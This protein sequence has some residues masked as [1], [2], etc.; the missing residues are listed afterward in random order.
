M[1]DED[2]AA[3]Y[4]YW[5]DLKNQDVLSRRLQRKIHRYCNALGIELSFFKVDRTHYIDNDRFEQLICY[6]LGLFGGLYTYKLGRCV[7]KRNFEEIPIDIIKSLS[8]KYYET[9]FDVTM[10][11]R[12][13][14]HLT[15]S[16]ADYQEMKRLFVKHLDTTNCAY[17]T[18]LVETF[19][20]A[21]GFA[22]SCIPLHALLDPKARF[23]FLQC[24]E[25]DIATTWNK[26]IQEYTQLK[27][28][29]FTT[30]TQVPERY[31]YTVE[32]NIQDSI[33][34]VFTKV[35]ENIDPNCCYN[36]KWGVAGSTPQTLPDPPASPATTFLYEMLSKRQ[37]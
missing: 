17:E 21:Y 14:V 26:L 8:R 20:N 11:R 2:A 25:D 23:E 29:H 36:I 34:A 22:Q 19:P 7:L 18:Y 15:Q 32:T 35:S 6:I 9:L 4:A 31:P 12:N 13:G 33:A 1:N 37:N 27:L 24:L 3:E 10:E 5:T 28:D 16:D 30:I